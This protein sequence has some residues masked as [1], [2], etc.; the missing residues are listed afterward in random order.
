MQESP[1]AALKYWTDGGYSFPT[2]LDPSSELKAHF[3]VFTQP[4]TFYLDAQGNEVS[5]KNGPMSGEEIERR[6]GEL[7]EGDIEESE[8]GEEYEERQIRNSK[9]EI[10]ISPVPSSLSKWY[11]GKVNHLIPLQEI[12]SGGPPKDGIP[13]IDD[14]QFLLSREVDFLEDDDVGILVELDGHVKFYPY[15]ILN[16][17]EIVNDRMAGEDI[18]VSY[19]PLCA[20]GVVYS[21]LISE[22]SSEFGVSGFLYQSNLLMY[23]RATD[24]LWN[25]VTGQAVVG[26]LTGE[27]LHRIKSDI[28]RYSAAKEASLDLLVL[29]TDT[30]HS[31][32]YSRTP[33][34]GYETEERTIFPTNAAGDNRLHPKAIVYGVTIDD[35]ALAISEDF[36]LDRGVFQGYLGEGVQKIPLQIEYDSRTERLKI[37]R[38]YKDEP[39]RREELVLIP[40]FWFSWLSMYPET[41][42][43]AK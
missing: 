14:P 12:L 2:L 10:R 39:G 42:L 8:D 29:S 11:Q 15:A 19:C 16:W 28:V 40:A 37:T 5:K 27:Y 43:M 22:G 36:I 24:S 33:Y 30:G 7:L 3:D 21:S 41:K 13:S 23:D 25:Q 35:K 4:T 18:T 32:D 38:F 20:T 26:P 9:F 1:K 6:M 31:R 17:H 34:A